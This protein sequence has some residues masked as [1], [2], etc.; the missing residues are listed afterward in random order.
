MLLCYSLVGVDH[1]LVVGEEFS[2]SSVSMAWM[3]RASNSIHV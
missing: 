1:G 2:G 3:I